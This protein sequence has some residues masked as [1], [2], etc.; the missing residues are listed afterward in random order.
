[1]QVY[2][3]TIYVRF[4]VTETRLTNMMDMTHETYTIIPESLEHLK[5]QLRTDFQWI[6]PIDFRYMYAYDQFEL[7]GVLKE[8]EKDFKV[9]RIMKETLNQQGFPHKIG[10]G[11]GEVLLPKNFATMS[12]R[13][14][15]HALWGQGV[16]AA[17]ES[18]KKENQ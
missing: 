16:L 8:G 6:V 3:T 4:D 7:M 1:M 14:V 9:Q 15:L 5:K 17:F 2:G 10:V 13:D 12:S 18:F 11:T